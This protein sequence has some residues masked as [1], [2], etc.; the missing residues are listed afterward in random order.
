M[1]RVT[2]RNPQRLRAGAARGAADCD[3]LDFDRV[4]S[5]ADEGGCSGAK[6]DLRD[7]LA[8]TRVIHRQRPAAPM[9]I[10]A[11]WAGAGFA[12]GLL[13]VLLWRSR[14]QTA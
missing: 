6:M 10:P 4:S 7:Q 8:D 9:A 5:M 3:A 13:T 1:N 11:L 12:A 2:Q 14:A